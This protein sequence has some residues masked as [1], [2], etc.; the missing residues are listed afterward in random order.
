MK[1]LSQRILNISGSRTVQLSGVIDSLRR[2]GHDIINLGIGEPH[3]APFPD[4]LSKTTDALKGGETRYGPVSGIPELR[5][6]IAQKYDGYNANNII[7]TNGSKQALYTALQVLCNPGDQVIIPRPCWVSFCEQIKLT[8]ATP[9]MVDTKSHQLDCHGIERA[10]NGHTKAIIINSPN[11]PTGAV[12]P[13]ED[14]E[15]IADL[16][17]THDLY[18]ISDEAYEAFV[19]DGLTHNSLFAFPHTRD[20][21]I[22]AGSFS[23]THCMTGFRIGYAAASKEVI[24][25]MARLQSHLTGNVC[26]FG[27]HGALAATKRDPSHFHQW[28]NELRKKRD[29]TLKILKGLPCPTPRGAF[30]V[31]PDVTRLLK[32]NETSE[33]F[34]KEILK[35]VNVAVTPGEAFGGNGHIRICYAIEEKRLIEGLKRLAHVINERTGATLL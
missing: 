31:F 16:A 5:H 3:E 17:Q 32:K 33:T 22:I 14:L 9:V 26:T 7:I 12:Y 28:R 30:Y 24:N 29:L 18:L 1:H 15:K 19:Y 34:A 25:A 11:N 13:R 4:I 27:Q 10:I 6:A 20:R 2:H 21:L 23:K 35:R 8:G